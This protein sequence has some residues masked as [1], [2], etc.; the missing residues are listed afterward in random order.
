MSKTTAEKIEI[1]QAFEQGEAVEFKPN[2]RSNW[3]DMDPTLNPPWD[4][5]GT[6]YRIKSKPVGSGYR[7]FESMDEFYP[8]RNKWLVGK[9]E[10]HYGRPVGFDDEQLYG[11]DGVR[12]T[13]SELT[14][15]FTFE[16]GTPCGVLV[17]PT[18][19]AAN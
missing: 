5:W 9:I 10:R 4:W 13:Y 8:H 7:P 17:E 16:D 3:D 12:I 6:D 15:H 1:M 18:E 11:A 2:D 14:E 19:V